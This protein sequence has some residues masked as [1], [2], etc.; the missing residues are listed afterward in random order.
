[1]KILSPEELI[2][3]NLIVKHLAGS[4]AY[5][6]NI[7]TSDVDYRG[8]FVAEPVY[9]R[10]PFFTIKEAKDTTEE[11]TVIYE[12]SQFMKLALECN[13]NVV[14]SLWVDHA[15]IVHTTPAYDLLRQHNKDFL[16]SKIAFT[17]AGYAFQQLKRIRGHY[18]NINNPQ[19]VNPPKQTNFVS[20]VH[21]FTDEK[22]FK[23]DITQYHKGY[24]L[25]PYSGDTYGLYQWDGYETYDEL[26]TLNTTYEDE[27]HAEKIPLFIVKFNKSEYNIAKDKWENYWRWKQNRN[28]LRAQLEEQHNFD[29]KHAMH[30]V[31]LL[32]ISEEVLT[33][34]VYN[35]LR[36]DAQELLEIRDGKWSYDELIE[37]AEDKDRY[38]REVLY[39]STDLPKNPNYKLAAKVMMDIQD[40]VWSEK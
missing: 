5:G 34:G 35:V 25:V 11:D 7:E 32:R 29:T 4:H 3:Q 10:T 31:R 6:T 21:N 15:H 12:L 33:T 38:V 23:I 17:T 36:E 20:L 1:M 9:I 14:E 8:I 37:Y 16:C 26:F 18:K 30:L 22:L 13:P 19:D 40:M 24:R 28:P 39:V 2:K 27:A